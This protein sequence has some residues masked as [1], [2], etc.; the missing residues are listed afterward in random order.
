[1][2][3]E[4]T[5]VIKTDTKSLAALK[6]EIKEI[7]SQLDLTP[8]GTKEYDALVV[9]LRQAK[10]EIKDFK[11]ATK[12]LD[13]DQRAAKLVN[14]FRG[15]TGA[16][17]AAAGAITLFGGSGKALEEV[18][19]NLLGI[20]AIGGGI[21]QTIELTDDEIAQLE[22]DRA[23]WEVE[24]LAREAKAEAKATAR[25]S[26]LAKLAALGLSADELAAL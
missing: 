12:G 1:M 9:K 22:I 4:E 3:I 17:Q 10:G 8:S 13:P 16:I 26:A 21:Q 19:K 7:Q 20:I 11:E 2:A 15:M 6:A 25:A 5:V 24:R 18:E 23:N 14:A